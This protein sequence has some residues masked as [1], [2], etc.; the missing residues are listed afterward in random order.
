MGASNA[1]RLLRLCCVHCWCVLGGC[2][3]SYEVL[4]LSVL[5]FFKC[6]PGCDYEAVEMSVSV[7]LRLVPVG[8]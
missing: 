4:K 2:L 5:V 7:C 3:C 6:V 8:L 1:K